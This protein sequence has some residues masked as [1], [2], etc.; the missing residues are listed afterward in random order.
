[1][2]APNDNVAMPD[3]PELS[4]LDD[5]F[6]EAFSGIGLADEDIYAKL[7]AHVGKP[8]DQAFANEIASF[9]TIANRA[10]VE[11][12]EKLAYIQRELVNLPNMGEQ[13]LA[14]KVFPL[15]LRWIKL[16]CLFFF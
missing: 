7:D 12:G 9:Y 1:M 13:F 5:D 4:S 2:S 15:I 16:D 14:L 3:A 11:L 8:L 6:I 10:I